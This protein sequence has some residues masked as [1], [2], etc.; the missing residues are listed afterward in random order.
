MAM[1]TTLRILELLKLLLQRE[2]TKEEV[3]QK[4]G[5]QERVFFRYLETLKKAG[6]EV[7]AT[8]SKQAE[9]HRYSASL[10]EFQ[11]K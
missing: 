3:C 2:H 7:S 11:D 5:I 10:G 6:F 1:V 8:A 4:L 9:P